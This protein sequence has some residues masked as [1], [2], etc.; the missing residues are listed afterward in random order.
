V[1]QLANSIQ[2][3]KGVASG[4]IKRAITAAIQNAMRSGLEAFDEQLV[5]I[6]N[7]VSERLCPAHTSMLC[8][9]L[10]EWSSG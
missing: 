6:R 4:I 9:E 7:S 8:I 5:Q 3:V 1:W 2:F 10:L